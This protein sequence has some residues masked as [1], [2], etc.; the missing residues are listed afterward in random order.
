MAIGSKGARNGARMAV[1]IKIAMITAPA[2]ANLFPIFA[3]HKKLE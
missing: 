3:T 1:T 2:Q